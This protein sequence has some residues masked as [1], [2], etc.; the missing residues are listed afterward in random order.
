LKEEIK[1]DSGECF[2]AIFWF[3]PVPLLN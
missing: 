2:L 3:K 1:H